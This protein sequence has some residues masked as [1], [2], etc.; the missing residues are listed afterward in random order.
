MTVR[1]R[2]GTAV[3]PVDEGLLFCGW[4][5]SALMTCGP[6]VV[7]VW[8]AVEPHLRQLIEPDTLRA[9]LPD[10]VAKVVRSLFDQLGEHGML[11]AAD[12]PATDD[13]LTTAL[14]HQ[15]VDVDAA[16]SQAAATSVQLIGA[17]SQLVGLRAL[18][19]AFLLS[20]QGDSLPV[21]LGPVADLPAETMLAG[22][23]VGAQIMV[24]TTPVGT[25]RLCQAAR[26]L[27]PA[28]DPGVGWVTARSVLVDQLYRCL[29][30][31]VDGGRAILVDG[32]L[33][34]TVKLAPLDRRPEPI[35]WR[36]VPVDA[37]ETGPDDSAEP[38]LGARLIGPLPQALAQH[39]LARQTVTL[40]GRT[41]DGAGVDQARA[42]DDALLAAARSTLDG[43]L[44]AA[45]RGGLDLLADALGRALVALAAPPVRPPTVADL[46][47]PMIRRWLATAERFGPVEV[48]TDQAPQSP[49]VVVATATVGPQVSWGYGATTSEAIEHALRGLLARLVAARDGGDRVAVSHLIEAG[50][51]LVQAVVGGLISPA[52]CAVRIETLGIRVQPW[53][54]APEFTERGLLGAT[55]EVQP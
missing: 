24:A 38:V 49:A 32:L 35:N 36:D 8:Q 18:L 51:A 17:A 50:R 53:T 27:D 15:A 39:P 13:P 20:D 4:Q 31:P 37:V 11:I 47:H 42:G 41:F 12:E 40:D 21:Y 19:P 16:W 43:P 29:A 46:A 48:R 6:G 54:L 28:G 30:G 52:D 2:P 44:T 14:L 55:V 3:Y 5:S 7:K 1:L 23:A 25:A 34:R 33:A 45:G 10:P 26:T 9:Q 22:V